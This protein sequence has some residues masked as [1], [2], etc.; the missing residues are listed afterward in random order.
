MRIS[1]WSSDVCS[2]DLGLPAV[3]RQDSARGRDRPEASCQRSARK[4]ESCVLSGYRSRYLF[5]LGSCA[6]LRLC[7][8]NRGD[9]CV[10]RPIRAAE[11]RKSVVLGKSVPVRVVL[12]G[13]R[14]IKKKKKK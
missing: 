7:Q 13:G 3:R 10:P 5:H 8:R 2:S 6:I 12:G 1:H 9:S 4:R 11:D 14:I